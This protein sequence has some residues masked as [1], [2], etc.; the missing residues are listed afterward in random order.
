MRVWVTVSRFIYYGLV[1]QYA[2][3][4]LGTWA[5]GRIYAFL[6]QQDMY[7]PYTYTRPVQPM[8]LIPFSGSLISVEVLQLS[9]YLGFY[10]R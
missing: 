2:E 5:R 7:Q 4:R 6:L 10:L 1:R 9:N 8:K 3:S